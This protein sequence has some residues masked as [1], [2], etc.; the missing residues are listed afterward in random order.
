MNGEPPPAPGPSSS[1]P[2]LSPCLT[3][4]PKPHFLL[5]YNLRFLYRYHDPSYPS[6]FQQA[7][8]WCV[9]AADLQQ[10]LADRVSKAEASETEWRGEAVAT[11]HRLRAAQVS[12]HTPIDGFICKSQKKC[13]WRDLNTRG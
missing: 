9:Q 8:V 1:T 13:Y 4:L 11:A 6:L 3:T 12:L 7:H 10:Q 5:S 2:C